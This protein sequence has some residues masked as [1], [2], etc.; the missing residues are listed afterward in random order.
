[1]PHPTVGVTRQLL[2][3]GPGASLPV[4]RAGWSAAGERGGGGS[5]P[6]A[7]RAGG[8]RANRGRQTGGGAGGGAGEPDRIAD[9]RSG[10]PGPAGVPDGS[11]S[12]MQQAVSRL[13]SAGPWSQPPAARMHLP[14]SQQLQLDPG[15]AA[16]RVPTRVA[17]S[18]A[19]SRETS[20]REV[21]I[22]LRIQPPPAP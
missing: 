7:E 21:A 4:R 9:S 5:G 19:I 15:G 2:L 3:L 14:L 11:A 1:M 22:E 8:W 18:P 6:V 17:K 13:A 16:G 12:A 10:E 20:G